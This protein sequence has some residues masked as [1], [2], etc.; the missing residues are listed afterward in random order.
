MN[1]PFDDR[2]PQIGD[3]PTAVVIPALNEEQAI[4]HVIDAIPDWIGQIIVVDNGSTDRTGR[5]AADHGARVVYQPQRGYGAACLAGIE[6]L[7]DCDVV[8]FCDGDHSDHPEAMGDLVDPIARGDAD[9]VIGSRVRGLAQRGALSPVQ[10]FGNW[11]A[12]GLLRL[13]WRVE[14]TDLGPFRAIRRTALTALAMDDRDYGWTV[15]MQ[16][17]AARLGLRCVEVPTDYRRRI[18]TSKITG[19]LSGAAG[20]GTKIL[21]TIFR[22]AAADLRQRAVRRRPA[23]VI[24]FTRYPVAG[25]AK[26]RMISA[27]G[28]QG[29]ADLQRRLTEHV[30][31]RCAGLPVEVRYDGADRQTMAQWLGGDLRY[32]PQGDGDLGTRLHRA[33]HEAFGAGC[34]RVIAI[35]ADCPAIT[36]RLLRQALRRL[37]DRDV[38]IG[39][40]DDGGYCLI[41][42]QQACPQLFTAIDW[43]GARVFDQTMA[44]AAR[45]GLTAWVLPRL[46][47][48]D[49]PD[50]LPT[51]RRF[52]PVA[53]E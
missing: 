39:P 23:R 28:P 29:A 26:T 46:D 33:F 36:A 37:G 3:V 18:G 14:S 49:R 24:L 48:V 7:G 32:R 21:Y 16:A 19:T 13:I 15:Q 51:A 6:A 31:A 17:R 12:N 9:L 1:R 8:A 45:L 11:L 42:L 22:E 5:V 41:G 40:A 4:G 2:S 30:L 20:A 52:L 27:L 43:G 47:D 38:V 10:R 35:G 53:A 50:D 25:K 44:A 34:D